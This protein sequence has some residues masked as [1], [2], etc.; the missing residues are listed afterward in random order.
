MGKAAR[1]RPAELPAKL[2]RIREALGLTQKQMIA[3]LGF[4]FCR[5]SLSAFERGKLEPPFDV[6]LAYARAANIYVEALID[7]QLE[8]PDQLPCQRKSA[9]KPAR[10][11]QVK[12]PASKKLTKG[13][14]GSSSV[15]TP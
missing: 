11:K 10:K 15:F 3:R 13:H 14:A 8:L 7:D 6:L 4:S 1:S 12:N 9:G 2:K 5:T